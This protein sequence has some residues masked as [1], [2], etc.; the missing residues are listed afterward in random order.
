MA[1]PSKA[2]RLP[3]ALKEAL[4]E[5]WVSGR[6]TLDQIKAWLDD[7]A[8]GKRSLL[9]PELA[10][11]AEI[12]VDPAA[13]PSRSGLGRHFKGLDGL[14][15][16]LQR[17]RAVAEA[18]VRKLGDAPEDRTARLNIE[19][20]HSIVT[21]LVMSLPQDGEDGQPVTLDPES[22]M[23]LARSLKDLAS[24]RKA[25]ADLV[26]RLR[27]EMAKKAAAKVDSAAKE[28]AKAG[29]LAGMA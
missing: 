29:E 26:L 12:A 7:L 24:A 5:L 25:D 11:V 9:P 16:R 23:F 22:V 4:A 14:A 19:L 20:M 10:A 13:L 3:G 28:A 17:S 18:L 15:E 8:A 6:Y 27:Q 1:G 21:D 2:D